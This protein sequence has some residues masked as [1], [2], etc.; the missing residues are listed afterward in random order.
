LTDEHK[1]RDGLIKFEEE[2]ANLYKKYQ[3]EVEE[4]KSVESFITILKAMIQSVKK[5]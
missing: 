4:T 1:L 5:L 3:L 2:R